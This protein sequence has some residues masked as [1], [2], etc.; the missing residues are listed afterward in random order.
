MLYLRSINR[1][2]LI[3]LALLSLSSTSAYAS[4]IA[5]DESVSGD[6]SGN[7]FTLDMAGTNTWIGTASWGGVIGNELD[8]FDILV[9][10]AVQVTGYSIDFSNTTA[11]PS[12]SFANLFVSLRTDANATLQQ[13]TLQFVT[14][15]HSIDFGPPAFPLMFAALKVE[16]GGS[17]SV[18]RSD[19]MIATDYKISVLTSA[20][21]PVPVPAAVWLFGTALIGLVGFGKR[22]KVA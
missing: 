6:I 9:D 11:T 14:A 12:V 3:S 1:F 13:D 7:S 10:S 18:N 8:Y 22:R 4:L 20:I 2:I 16:M 5:Y 15:A 19:W 17:A 21:S